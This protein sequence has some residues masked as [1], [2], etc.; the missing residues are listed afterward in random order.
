MIN[1]FGGDSTCKNESKG[2]K[3]FF[4]RTLE[5]NRIHTVNLVNFVLDRIWLISYN[6]R[7]NISRAKSS[8]GYN[9][10]LIDR[11]IS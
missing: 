4:V 7:K 10:K 11:N 3:N 6:R 5:N 9:I 8:T 1:R 2:K